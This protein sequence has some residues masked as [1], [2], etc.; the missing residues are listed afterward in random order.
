MQI[1]TNMKKTGGIKV[2][3]L[4]EKDRNRL[5]GCQSRQDGLNTSTQSSS[6][7]ELVGNGS[8]RLV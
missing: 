1:N 7:V 4:K 3:L 5:T 2:N 8:Q 6:V